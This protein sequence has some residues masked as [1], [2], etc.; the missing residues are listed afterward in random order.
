MLPI[1]FTLLILI[2]GSFIID[3][4]MWFQI[5]RNYI[6][7]KLAISGLLLDLMIFGCAWWQVFIL[8]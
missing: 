2:F 5:K 4:I 1:V 3:G 7:R 8:I 6:G